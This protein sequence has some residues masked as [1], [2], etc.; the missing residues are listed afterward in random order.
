MIACADKD[1]RTDMED[2]VYTV[3]TWVRGGGSTQ[4]AHFTNYH[5]AH[6]AYRH[7]I[8]PQQGLAA[9]LTVGKVYDTNGEIING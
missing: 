4:R 7:A 9:C 6:A 5:D 1:K 2:P 3:L 8:D